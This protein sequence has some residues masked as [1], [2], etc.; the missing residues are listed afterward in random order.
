MYNSQPRLLSR[1]KKIRVNI[2]NIPWVFV[3]A[4]YTSPPHDIGEPQQLK[5]PTSHRFKNQQTLKA[6]VYPSFQTA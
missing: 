1:A 4:S 5:R 3:I 6:W 2:R